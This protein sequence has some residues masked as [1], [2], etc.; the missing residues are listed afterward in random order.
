MASIT[1]L[2]GVFAVNPSIRPRAGNCARWSST[3]AAKSAASN[4]SPAPAAARRTAVSSRRSARKSSRSVR[5]TQR[6]TRSTNACHSKTWNAC[7]PST[8]PSPNGCLAEEAVS[9]GGFGALHQTF[10]EEQLDPVERDA[11]AGVAAVIGLDN[12]AV[13]VNQEIGGH[14]VG[15]VESREAHDAQPLEQGRDPGKDTFPFAPERALDAVSLMRAGSRV[16][17]HHERPWFAR[18]E[19]PHFLGRGGEYRDDVQ[20]QRRQAGV[21]VGQFVDA[22]VAERAG[23]VPEETQTRAPTAGATNSNGFSMDVFQRQ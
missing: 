13:L 21:M 1:R 11:I 16:G 4:P 10:R 7:R 2:N 6:S 22:E 9:G 15:G 19:T 5:S 12:A 14:Q 3:C 23:C 8:S 18:H 20:A 17:D